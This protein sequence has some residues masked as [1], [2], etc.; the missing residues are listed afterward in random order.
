MKYIFV[1]FSGK[2]YG[3]F[4]PYPNEIT[5]NYHIIHHPNININWYDHKK[6]SKSYG[7]LKN[8]NINEIRFER[9]KIR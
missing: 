5:K 8:Q 6:L 9:V 4:C 1:I 3:W 2:Y 7:F